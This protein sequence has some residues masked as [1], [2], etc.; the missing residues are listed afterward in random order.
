VAFFGVITSMSFAVIS[1]FNRGYDEF[2][3]ASIDNDCIRPRV[4]GRLGLLA[5]KAIPVNGWLPIVMRPNQ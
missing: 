2:A 3:G 5:R 1:T 4:R